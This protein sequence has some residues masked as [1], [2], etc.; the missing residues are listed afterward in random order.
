MSRAGGTEMRLTG[1]DVAKLEDAVFRADHPGEVIPLASYKAT[2]GS[3]VPSD[4]NLE[5]FRIPLHVTFDV[6]PRDLEAEL[7][8]LGLV[9]PK[10]KTEMTWA[11]DVVSGP[12][13][14]D[15]IRH[16]PPRQP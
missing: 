8:E 3:L 12:V 13:F 9:I 4:L 15:G 5:P 10:P 7:R 1:D 2:A 14:L 6:P 11:G 16:D